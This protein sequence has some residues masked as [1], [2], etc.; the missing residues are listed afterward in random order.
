[1][2]KRSPCKARRLLR[3]ARNDSRGRCHCEE[4]SDEA[5]S[6][7]RDRRP[8]TTDGDRM[9]AFDFASK[10]CMLH[11]RFARNVPPH[12]IAR[13]AMT[14]RS[15]C[16]ARRLLRFARNDN[17]CRCHCEERSDE[18]IPW[19]ADRRRRTAYASRLLRSQLT[20]DVIARSAATKQSPHREGDCFPHALLGTCA[21]LAMTAWI[22][23]K[24]Q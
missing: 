1:M 21:S 20:T 2:T 8:Q 11:G 5:I 6:G 3:F 10:R 19:T 23:G 4:R 12:V 9:T 15:P 17:R 13:R 7:T 24:N 16:K 18:A 14:K 22:G